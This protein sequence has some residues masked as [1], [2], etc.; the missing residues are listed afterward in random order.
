MQLFSG[1]GQIGAKTITIN[2]ALMS[3]QEERG[4]GKKIE[5]G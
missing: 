3:E 5:L 4:G 2:N 1:N